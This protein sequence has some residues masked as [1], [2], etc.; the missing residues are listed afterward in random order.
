MIYYMFAPVTGPRTFHVVYDNVAMYVAAN[1]LY[2]CVRACVCVLT[3]RYGRVIK[4]P[5]KCT[6]FLKKKKYPYKSNVCLVVTYIYNIICVYLYYYYKG[7]L[8][9]QRNRCLFF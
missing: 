5:K 7:D 1:D 3:T 6:A 4:I 9:D 8:L 2:L